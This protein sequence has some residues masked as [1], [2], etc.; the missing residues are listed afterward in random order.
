MLGD[1][2]GG[3]HGIE[4]KPTDGRAE[5]GAGPGPG[6]LGAA[7]GAGPGGNWYLADQYIEISGVPDGVYV[8]ET[9]ANPARTVRETTFADNASRVTIRLQGDTVELVSGPS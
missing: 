9:V 4:A 2:G 7:C 8:L 3:R 6:G 1:A 5:R